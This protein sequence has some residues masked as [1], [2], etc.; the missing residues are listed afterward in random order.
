MSDATPLSPAE[1]VVLSKPNI[2]AG[3]RAIKVTL[4]LLLTQGML[5]IEQTEQPGLLRTKKVPH[6]RIAAEPKEAP[7]EALALI[8]IV[9][10]AQ[11]DG[12]KIA[13]VIKRA[14][15]EYGPGCTQFVTRLI[16]PSLVARGLLT[17][18]KVLFVRTFHLTPAGEA[19]R[20]RLNSDL[21]KA[22]DV[23]RLLKSDPAQ[24]A[25]LAASLGTTILLSDKL[26]KQFKP[27]A[28]AMRERGTG[29]DYVN[30]GD[31]DGGGF[32]FGSFDPGSFDAG[33]L[34]AGMASFD[35]GF[36][37]GGGDSSSGN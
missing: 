17:E 1:L 21:F 7:P 30:A 36:S 11:A 25:V 28:G 26:T 2:A 15:K 14:S 37:D 34:D 27:L 33:S 35:A 24:A 19:A 4:L 16:H 10:A 8:E 29:G 18:K 5:R 13:D 23:A 32:D 9:R 12:G 22:D 3:L 6:L 31:V 20:A